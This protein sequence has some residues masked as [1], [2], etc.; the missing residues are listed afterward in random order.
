[1]TAERVPNHTTD[2]TTGFIESNAYVSAFDAS[3]KA[4]FLQ[5]FKANGLGLYKTCR[6]LGL[7]CSTIHHHY[8][9]DPVF[10]DLV[11]QLREEYTDELEATS[12]SN[13]LN[14]KSVIERIFQLKALLP[15]KYGDQKSQ[16]PM[17]ITLNIDGKLLEMVK[18][19]DEI[20]E[21][22]VITSALDLARESS[23]LTAS[24]D[25]PQ[26]ITEA[27]D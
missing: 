9:I 8:K 19:R 15:N 6:Q 3:R 5:L 17:Q 21:T 25:Q 24:S 2:P 26:S 16:G 12:R 14:P 20:L 11:D 22:Q 1:M 7:S 13:A 4:Q 23:G 18:K 27:S 10:K